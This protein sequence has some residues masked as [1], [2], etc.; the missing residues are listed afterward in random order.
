[1]KISFAASTLPPAG[2]LVLGINDSKALGP[3]AKQLDKTAAGAIGKAIAASRFAGKR[4]QTL[5]VMAP[6]NLKLNRILLL[7]LGKEIELNEAKI[8]ALGAAV[9]GALAKSG[10]AKIHLSVETSGKTKVDN[11]KLA[12]HL[13]MGIYLR[14]YSFDKYLT[15][16]KPEDKPSVEQ[17]VIF[18]K[19]PRKAEQLYAP[20]QKVGEAVWFTRDLI[21]EPPNVL[22]PETFANR[23]KALS[24]LGIKIDVLG[25]KEMRQLGMGALLGV[26]QGSVQGPRL[27]TMSY[28]G[29]KKGGQPLALV[30]KGV[31]F[32]TG[33]ISI[34]PS[35]GMEEMK[36]DMAGAAAVTGAVMALAGRKAKVN[37]VGVLG[38]VENMPSGSAQRPGDIVKTMSGQ[39]AEVLNTDAE[40]RLVLCDA[41]WYT[42]KKFKPKA[43]IDLATLTGAIIIALGS[44]YAGIFS[45]NNKLANDLIAAG[46]ETG[47]LL[48]R[49]PL[50][51]NYD[52]QIN[53][54]QADMKNISGGR[55]A[56]SSIAAHFIGRF[57]DKNLPWAH[58]DIAGVAWSKKDSGSTPKG[59]F[60]FGVRL[61]E[62][63][64]AD[65]YEGK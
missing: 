2:T 28:N 42:Q 33:G 64:I 62:K 56:G 65:H 59:A 3:F 53:A 38:L 23:V 19:N 30:G 11:A 13:G 48:W 5:S 4:G 45:N 17:V 63:F 34:K 27:V 21:N 55:E 20:L 26:A 41:V 29:G 35:A 49:M 8:E 10:E 36:W 47:E 57:I 7:G 16:T 6:A 25:E 32:D 54:D 60:A 43:L 12:A 18:A 9:Y 50:H 44:E 52:K 46:E 24:K 51:E 58:I 39:T 40:G 15:K 22:Y 31:T 1:M 37:V 14:S 61:L